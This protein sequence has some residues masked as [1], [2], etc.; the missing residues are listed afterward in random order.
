[1]TTLNPQT[2]P[3][4]LHNSYQ[5]YGNNIALSYVNEDSYSYKRLYSEVEK[6][7]E[8]LFQQGIKK[9]D[10]V[11]I[12]SRNMPNWGIAFFYTLLK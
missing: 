12:L 7:K 10:K 11:G 1:M 9:G 8:L 3:S 6:I 4:L 2:L 5:L